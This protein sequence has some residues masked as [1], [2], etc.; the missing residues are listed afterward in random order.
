MQVG[1]GSQGQEMSLPNGC[2]I[3]KRIQN[4]VSESHSRRSL[5]SKMVLTSFRMILNCG[6]SIVRIGNSLPLPKR[7]VGNQPY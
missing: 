5:V 7:V 2:G 4:I 1:L 3:G 6:D